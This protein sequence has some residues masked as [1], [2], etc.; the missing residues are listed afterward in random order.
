MLEWI[1]SLFTRRPPDDELERA[2]RQ[3]ETLAPKVMAV[4]AS[5]RET[6]D[7]IIADYQRFDGALR[8]RGV[9]R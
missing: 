2:Q 9:A 1:R 8:R 7:K 4:T 5:M 3:R 6:H